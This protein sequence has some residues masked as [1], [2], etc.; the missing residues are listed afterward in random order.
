M[1]QTLINKWEK[2]ILTL[3]GE[4]EAH[5]FHW[6]PGFRWKESSNF[7]YRRTREHQIKELRSKLK[8]EKERLRLVEHQKQNKEL[9]SLGLEAVPEK[10]KGWDAFVGGLNDVASVV[11]KPARDL[12]GAASDAGGPVFERVADSFDN[13]VNKT[14]SVLS[15]PIIWIAGGA[16]AF[17][18]V[19]KLL[20]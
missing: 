15:S 13:T 4:I 3:Q 16:V 6:S 14:S 7:R 2:E 1:S 10:K 20:K 12:I 11:S 18:V 17:L 19:P 9:E 5:P 8:E